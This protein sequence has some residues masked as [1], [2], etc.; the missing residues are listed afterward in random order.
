MDLRIL[1]LGGLTVELRGQPLPA[2]AAQRKALALLALLAANSERGLSRDKIAAYLWPDADTGQARNSLAQLVYRIRRELGGDP[3]TGD[4]E[5]R[6][7]EAMI[8]S[9]VRAFR[10]AVDEGNH[11]EATG[12]YRGDFLDGF[13]LREAPEFERW[14]DAERRSLRDLYAQVLRRLAGD[15]RAAGDLE[16]AS[17]WRQRQVELDPLNAEL[18]LQYMESLAE[19]GNR[20]GAI[21]HASVYAALVATELGAKPDG[22]VMA[23]AEALRAS[24]TAPAVERR[25]REAPALALSGASDTTLAAAVAAAPPVATVSPRSGL[26][27]VLVAAAS[28]ALL[29]LLSY[30]AVRSSGLFGHPA[31]TQPILIAVLPFENRGAARDDYFADGITDAVRGKLASLNELQVIARTSSAPYHGTSKSM[32]QIASEL[33][34]EYLVTGTIRWEKRVDGSSRVMVT[35]ELIRVSGTKVPIVRWEQPYNADLADVFK[36]Q[37]DIAYRVAKAIGVALSAEETL[38]LEEAPTRSLAAYD[39]YLLGEA[40]TAQGQTTLEGAEAIAHYEAALARDSM[41][42]P[43][44]AALARVLL[45]PDFHVGLPELDRRRAYAAAMRA[46]SLAPG[47][48]DGHLALAS[49]YITPPTDEPRARAE[50]DTARALGG[51]TA[52]LLAALSFMD[53]TLEAALGHEREARRFDPR[54]PLVAYRVARLAMQLRQYPEA[55]AE[56][57]RALAIQP[58]YLNAVGRLCVLALMQGDLAACRSLLGGAARGVEPAALVA[59]VAQYYDLDWVLTD[60]QQR[61]LTVLRASDFGGDTTAWGLALAQSAWLRGNRILARAYADTAQRAVHLSVTRESAFQPHSSL[62]LALAFMGRGDTAVAEGRRGVTLAW[63]ARR[64]ADRLF[65]DYATFQLV[66]IHLILG[67]GQKA[68]DVLEPLLKRPYW[69]TPAWLRVDPSFS[70]LKSD[71]RFRRLAGLPG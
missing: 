45:W 53:T 71:P 63:A 17:R 68:L 36:V 27:G 11:A 19:A 67:Q 32:G 3:F 40:N 41:F 42:A 10:R 51:P 52:D 59:S 22:R 8:D 58:N 21:R 29:A 48:P 18:A 14:V 64:D 65:A 62:G 47:R 1:A 9:D 24:Y 15:A 13:F 5:L 50:L 37:G 49:F 43:A 31:V 57:E 46:V 26:R 7:N 30:V 34:V 28:V 54:S 66:R 39:A 2:L 6:L 4:A 44:W 69:I 55:R 70:A 23:R 38:R 56:L 35:P 61:I 12:L 25:V 16:A 33:G 60:A 20:E